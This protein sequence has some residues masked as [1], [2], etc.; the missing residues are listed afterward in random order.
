MYICLI[1]IHSVF[2]AFL[3]SD[4]ACLSYLLRWGKLVASNAFGTAASYYWFFAMQK[5]RPV[6]IFI[7][8]HSLNSSSGYQ[9]EGNGRRSD[10]L[11]LSVGSS[12]AITLLHNSTILMHKRTSQTSKAAKNALLTLQY[13]QQSGDTMSPTRSL[14]SDVIT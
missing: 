8:G 3:G 5:A 12:L 4:I 13:C 7:L 14:T 6:M 9:H 2:N 1:M 10:C 11:C